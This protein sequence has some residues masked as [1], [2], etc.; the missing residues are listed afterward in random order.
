MEASNKSSSDDMFDH[1]HR[2]EATSYDKNPYGVGTLNSFD[3]RESASNA[4]SAD[5]VL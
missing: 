5:R 3:D 4:T 2:Y 1:E